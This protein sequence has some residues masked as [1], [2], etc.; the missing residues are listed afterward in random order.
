M[1]TILTLIALA[2]LMSSCTKQPV[3][4]LAVPLYAEDVK[5]IQA[6]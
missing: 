4:Y 1:K 2:A 5:E 6:K 3:G